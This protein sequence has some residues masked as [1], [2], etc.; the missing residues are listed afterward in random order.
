MKTFVLRHLTAAC[1]ST[2]VLFSAPIFSFAQNSISGSISDAGRRPVADI[3]VE[4]LDE[5]E[6]RLKAARTVG[7]GLYFFHGLRAGVYYI[8]VRV[9]GTAYL[10]AKER[11]QIG[12]TNRTN[13]RT[14]LITGS[15]SAQV[16]LT[17]EIDP[18]KRGSAGSINNEVIFAQEVPTEAK[19]LYGKALKEIEKNDR[20]AAIESLKAA[21][22]IFPDYYLALDRLGNEYL[23]QN[24]FI[25]AEPVFRRILQINANSFS[26]KYGLGITEYK[27]NK[28]AEAVKTLEEAAII[29]PESINSLFWLGK[30][31]RDLREFEKAENR[32]KKADK[33][34]KSEL[35]DIHW[36]LALLYYHNLNRNQDAANEL[37]LYLKTNPKADNKPQVEKLIKFLREKAK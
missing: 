22:Q 30:I 4:L 3:E 13:S 26:A 27:L 25:E 34:G 35:P 5:Y 17:L 36:E 6:R 24:K 7:S 14:G 2:V 32:F 16:N 11:I 9:A 33:L 29:N 10:P 8:Q 15:E 21:T 37:E 23:I 20:E 12:D 19:A 31:Y 18:Q 28:K 1:L